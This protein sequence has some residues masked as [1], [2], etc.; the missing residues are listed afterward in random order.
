M[1]DENNRLKL[2]VFLTLQDGKELA[3]DLIVNL[4][5]AIDRTLNNEARFILVG[6]ADGSE[7]LL[8][9]DAIMKV[10]DAKK[11]R[12]ASAAGAGAEQQQVQAPTLAPELSDPYQIL[13]LMAGASQDDITNAYVA[14]TQAY[15]AERVAAAQLPQDVADFCAQRQ[16]AINGAFA[17]LTEGQTPVL[18]QPA[19]PA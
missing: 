13:G 12:L 1:Q 6:D 19:R 9:K 8:A 5:G 3:V 14:Y 10:R 2:P 18:A 16:Q 15:S 11:A 7:Y 17:Q 4:G